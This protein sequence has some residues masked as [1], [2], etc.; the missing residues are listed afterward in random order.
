VVSSCADHDVT[1]YTNK[2]GACRNKIDS[3]YN[4]CTWEEGNACIA[5]K[6]SCDLYTAPSGGELDF[7]DL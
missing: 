6:A 5:K 7:C 4:S 3:S 2:L 1:N